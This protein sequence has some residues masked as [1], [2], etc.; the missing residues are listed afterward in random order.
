MNPDRQPRFQGDSASRAARG[1][2]G[3][4]VIAAL[5]S[6]V[7]LVHCLA[8]PLAITL[9]PAA[10]LVI[11]HAGWLHPL[12]LL[13]AIPASGLALL[14]GWRAH[15]HGAPAIVG[16]SGIAIMAA[17]LLAQVHSLEDMLTVGGGLV[18]A[19]GHVLNLR[20]CRRDTGALSTG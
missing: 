13:L 18:V 12:L 9:L 6:S 14:R 11:P 5:V 7:C 17:A 1:R 2:P 4:D 8:I 20:A 16:V 15:G 19:F 10:S 3:L